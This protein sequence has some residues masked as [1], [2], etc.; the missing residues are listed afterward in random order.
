MISFKGVHFAKDLILVGVR[1]YVAYPL[2]Y[3][4]CVEL[5]QTFLLSGGCRELPPAC[6]MLERLSSGILR[7]CCGLV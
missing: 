7:W 1:W 5:W 6:W 3:R 4:L 2:S